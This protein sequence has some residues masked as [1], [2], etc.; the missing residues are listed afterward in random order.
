MPLFQIQD[1]DTPMWIVAPN[2]ESALR[3]WRQHV[4]KLDSLDRDSEGISE[5]ATADETPNGVNFVAAHGEVM[6]VNDGSWEIL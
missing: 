2:M 3:A 1:P 4:F 5:D 6:I